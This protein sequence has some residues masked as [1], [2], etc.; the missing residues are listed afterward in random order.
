MTSQPSSARLWATAR[1][2]V[3]L[4]PSRKPAGSDVRVGVVQL[5]PQR[6][7]VVADGDRRVEPAVLTRRSSS[8]RRACRAK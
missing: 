4:S 5:D 8:S 7:A 3:S 1:M 2:R 6:A